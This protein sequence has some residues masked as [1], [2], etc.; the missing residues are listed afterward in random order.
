MFRKLCELLIISVC[1]VASSANYIM[2]VF[3]NTFAPAGLD[4]ICTMIQDIL[5]VNMGYF[6]FVANL[7]LLICA[8]LF[9]NRDFAIKT[10]VYV[11]CF[12]L[13]V[14]LLKNT[15]LPDFA[16]Y[17]ETGTSIVLAPIAA[18]GIRGV[19]YSVTLKFKGSSGGI[20]II[21]ALV[22]K[23]KPHLNLMN[24]IFVI[25][26]LI[27]IASYFVY[28]MKLEPVICSII[29]SF[30]TSNIANKMKRKLEISNNS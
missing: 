20:D 24:I 27:A 10:T 28:G 7:P 5:N 9:L 18:G 29:Y 6:S 8:F 12:S 23:K 4:G 2:L 14:I 1:A 25:N 11:V 16:Y 26:M 30:I 22:K 21:A 15:P 3:P 13:S 17:T 19:L